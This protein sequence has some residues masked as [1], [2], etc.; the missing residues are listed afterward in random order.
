MKP[1]LAQSVLQEIR[2][3]MRLCPGERVGVAVSGGADSVA[4]LLL[5]VE[6]RAR[7]GIILSVVH[8]NHKLRGRASDADEKFVAKL[9]AK[10]GLE[11][12]ADRADVA[13]KAKRD[14]LNVEDAARRARTAFFTRLAGEGRVTRVAVA[15]TADDQA[16]TVLAHILRG[17][18][19][20]GLGGIH[21]VA[22]VVFRPL[23]EIRRAE[24][25]A[26]LRAKKQPWR[27]D[28]SNRDTTRMRARIRKKLLPLLEKQFQTATVEHLTSLAELA[29][30]DEAFLKAIAEERARA[31]IQKSGGQAR[32]AVDDLLGPWG[33]K[34]FATEDTLAKSGQAPDTETRKATKALSKRLVRKIV[35]GLKM[36]GGQLGSKHV[37]AVLEL[38]RHGE[39]G[40]SLQ[41]PGGIEVR[42]ERSALVFCSTEGR[43]AAARSGQD[44]KS[45]AYEIDLSSEGALVQV[46]QLGCAFRL[47]VIDWPAQRGETIVTSA[48]MDSERLRSPL[49]L[50]S[51]RPGDTLHSLGRQNARKLKRLLNEKRISR[52]ERDGWPVLTSGGVIAWARGFPVAAEFAADERTRAGIVIAE[53]SF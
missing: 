29:R 1:N 16:E 22:G 15:H 19:L 25:R 23:L 17:T 45:Y 10:H 48:V 27:E 9:A 32:I 34:G 44:T 5:L 40:K 50:R 3:N 14:R 36:R 30:E 2:R 33:K 28:A 6:L 52:W 7:L 37:D 41:L 53:E 11:F 42:R 18:G 4:L 39:S 8:F 38:A 46:P 31:L 49:V 35:E 13:G 26:Y 51:W 43:K 20:A 21:P 47:R 12:H 24:L